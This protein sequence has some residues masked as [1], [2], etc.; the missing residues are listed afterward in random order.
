MFDQALELLHAQDPQMCEVVKLR[1]FAGLTVE[2]TALAMGVSRRNVDR[3]WAAAKA[4]LFH[5]L[6][7][8]KHE[9]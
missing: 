6:N 8:S 4:W 7:H 2:E 3:V 9:S 5:K 1:C